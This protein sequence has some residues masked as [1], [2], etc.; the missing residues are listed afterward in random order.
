LVCPLPGEPART[1]K[2]QPPERRT[3]AARARAPTQSRRRAAQGSFTTTQLF[4][5]FFW[6]IQPDPS[7]QLP[8]SPLSLAG[9]EALDPGAWNRLISRYFL[10]PVLLFQTV[11]LSVY[12]SDAC[13]WLRW[14]YRAL[15]LVALALCVL[16]CRCTTV[17]TGPLPIAL[18]TL[19]WGGVLPPLWLV[20]LGIALWAIGAAAFIRP[21]VVWAAILG[22]G[23]FNLG[24][25]RALDG[26]IALI[27]KLCFWCLL[28]SLLFMADPLW[29][30]KRPADPADPPPRPARPRVALGKHAK[31]SAPLLA[32]EP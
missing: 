13:R 18:P 32:A 6:S 10:P 7:E 8:C 30:P 14:P 15:I 19:L 3:R 17:W 29:M 1:Q 9:L 31:R 5:A 20:D 27:S 11:V 28:L 26:T 25:L 12:P 22:V 24:L 16:Y 23:G 2:P 21:N 4:D